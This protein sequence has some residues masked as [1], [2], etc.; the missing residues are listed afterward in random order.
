MNVYT[1]YYMK[2]GSF[3]KLNEP[4]FQHA[5]RFYK[6]FK[7][8]NGQWQNSRGNIFVWKDEKTC[9]KDFK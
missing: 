2:L 5:C 8:S 1:L 3:C 4:A 7:N 6:L 9:N